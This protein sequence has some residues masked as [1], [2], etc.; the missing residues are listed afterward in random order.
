MKNK[1]TA[2]LA[3]IMLV[4]CGQI[5]QPGQTSPTPI[6]YMTLPADATSTPTP[7][8]PVDD[9]YPIYSIVVTQ[10]SG[11]II[12]PLPSSTPDYLSIL[13]DSFAPPNNFDPSSFYTPFPYITDPETVTYLLLGSDI[14]SGTSFRTDTMIIVA[15]RP[16][17]GQISLI[18]IPRDLWVYIPT[19][20]MQR[21]NTAYLHGE[22]TRYPGGGPGL[23]KDTILYNLGIRI[24]HT[25]LVDFNGFKRILDTLG[26]IE[27][28]VACQFTDWHLID[29]NADQQNENNWSLYTIGPG[30]IQMDGD[31]ALWYARS[32]K[33]SSDF[34][35]GRRQQE[36]LR[37]VFSK[38]I[39]ANSISKIPKLYEDLNSFI[40]T[41]LSLS[42]IMKLAPFALSLNN[43]DIRSYYIRPPL[44][45]SWIT[46]QGAY[47]LSPNELALQ[48]MLRDAMSPSQKKVEIDP[49]RIEI[50]NGTSNPG[51]DVLAGERLNYAGYQTSLAASEQTNFAISLLYDF[52][53]TQDANKL[54]S[55]LAILGLPN[56]GVVSHPQPGAPADYLLV[57]GS[58]YKPCFNPIDLAP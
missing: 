8:Y 19:W 50:R 28:P 20:G 36:V 58:D 38:F 47:V 57:I 41:D 12:P 31:M 51:W 43:A 40:S 22:S 14:R 26:G 1:S 54:A 34:D 30:V 10:S 2:I 37:A 13:P 25:A 16:R 42:S 9:L 56:S 53:Q 55:L 44:V 52:T 35:R 45:F 4:A 39:R 33:K 29:P 15:L 7:F 46:S 49:V 6:L 48:A 21:I 23:I 24:D 5:P 18:S 32:R 27:V 3:L 11:E 17:L